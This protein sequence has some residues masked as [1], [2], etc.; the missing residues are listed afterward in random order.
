M[1][2][3]TSAAPAS[4]S[5]CTILRVVEPRTIES[6]TTTTRRPSMRCGSGLN[7]SLHAPL[8]QPLVGLDERAPDVAVLDQAL[9]ERDAAALR[10][11][12]CAAGRAGVGDADDDVGVGRGLVG[13]PL[14]HPAAD[15]VQGLAL[16]R[17]VGAGEVDELEDAERRRRCGSTACA[18]RAPCSSMTTSS[19]GRSSR[20]RR[21]PMRSSAHVSDASTQASSRR[22]TTS[23]RM[24]S[25]SRKPASARSERTTAA[26]A[27]SMRDIVSATASAR[28][29]DGCWAMSA[30]ITSVSDVDS[31]RTRRSRSSARSTTCWSGCRCGRA[32]SPRG[33]SGARSAGR[34]ASTVDPVVE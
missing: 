9:A 14:A 11:A 30:A 25:G 18:K 31:R 29:S 16:H 20:S 15:V 17:G 26:K 3:C 10:V 23:G 19:P 4:N 27:P 28:S 6:S 7:F 21:A 5:I 1:R 24:P 33:S 34:S 32:R 2:R 13:Q 12:D 22:P 8:A